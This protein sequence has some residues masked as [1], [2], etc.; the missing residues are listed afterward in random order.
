MREEVEKST[1]F[2]LAAGLS[3]GLI[4]PLTADAATDVTYTGDTTDSQHAQ[5]LGANASSP[6]AYADVTM[7]YTI[8]DVVALAIYTSGEITSAE[9]APLLSGVFNEQGGKNSLLSL[10]DESTILEDIVL[11]N[12]VYDN[13][14]TNDRTLFIRGV[15]YSSSGG[16]TLTVEPLI[17]GSAAPLLSN[18]I[19]AQF[20]NQTNSGS[21]DV[22]FAGTFYA[23]TD[24]LLVGNTAS[25]SNAGNTTLSVL[26]QGIFVID[27]DVL[28]P[29]VTAED[30]TGVYEGGI[31]I[32]VTSL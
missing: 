18:S 29:T 23:T 5:S 24:M 17:Q 7:D 1:K 12:N 16:C 32:T 8:P 2:L 27:G 11:Q 25:I 15:V 31:R 14:N 26:N 13:F 6:G 19:V 21:I 4:G 22:G 28:E 10:T 9:G 30:D 3:L 20:N